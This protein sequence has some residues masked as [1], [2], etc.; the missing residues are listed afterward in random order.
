MEVIVLAG[1]MGTR[2]SSVT[3]GQIPKPML[4][5]NN[6]PFL[7]YLLEWL[8]SQKVKKVI[9]AV[10]FKSEVIKNYFKNNF[11][12]M[13]II[14]SDE[15]NSKLGTGGAIKKAAAFVSDKVFFV[16]N[17]DTYFPISLSILQKNHKLNNADITI[18]LKKMNNIDRY[19]QV[20]V[21]NSNLIKA[22]LE[23]NNKM[24]ES[25]INGGVYLINKDIFKNIN[26]EKFSFEKQILEKVKNKTYGIE[27]KEDFIDIGIPK[28]YNIF[29]ERIGK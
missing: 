7:E 29:C 12:N 27:F 20:L 4:L 24:Q 6:K 28:D 9:L 3:K 16:V 5:V 13:E 22:F 2:I 23:K 15:G 18:A 21:D 17:G 25:L 11:N 10:G 1:G 8:S 26:E 19:G 14:Y